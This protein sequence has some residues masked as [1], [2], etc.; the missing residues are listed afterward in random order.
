MSGDPEDH[1]LDTFGATIAG[2]SDTDEII[3]LLDIDFATATL[4]YSGNTGS[5]VLTITDGTDTAT[6]N[7]IGQYTAASFTLAS[8]GAGGTLVWDPPV[9]QDQTILVASHHG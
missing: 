3:N 9:A 1:R 5:G 6:L 4:G 8:N 7:L 2:L